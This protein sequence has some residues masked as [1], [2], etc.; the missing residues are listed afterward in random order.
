M[1]WLISFGFPRMSKKDVL[2]LGFAYIQYAST[3]VLPVNSDGLNQS[4]AS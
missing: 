1:S 3:G 4:E 2:S